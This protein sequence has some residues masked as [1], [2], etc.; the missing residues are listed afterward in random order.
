MPVAPAPKIRQLVKHVE[1]SCRANDAGAAR[2]ALLDWAAAQWPQDPPQRID[3]LAQRL[4]ENAA[5]ALQ[6]LDQ[7]LYSGTA[8]PWDGVAA[9]E[10]LS[11]ALDESAI[12]ENSGR[13][14]SS[15]PPLYPQG[16]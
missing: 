10:Q 5:Q 6:K 11:V 12:S 13:S 3:T 4:G 2:R 14:D 15:L 1:Q 8:Q 16:A 7:C 9:W